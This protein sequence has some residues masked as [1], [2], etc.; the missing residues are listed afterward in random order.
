M[1]LEEEA[2][3]AAGQA[4]AQQIGVALQ[5]ELLDQPLVDASGGHTFLHRAG[6]VE[7]AEDR[8]ELIRVVLE[9]RGNEHAQCRLQAG[10][11]ERK[12]QHAGRQLGATP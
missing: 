7:A 4:R 6:E 8:L 12:C 11:L 10:E 5:R 2:F 1:I 9:Q 3:V